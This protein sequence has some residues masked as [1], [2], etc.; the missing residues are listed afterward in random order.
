MTVTCSDLLGVTVVLYGELTLYALFLLTPP[1][2]FLGF[3]LWKLPSAVR[4]LRETPIGVRRF[5]SSSLAFLWLIC[6]ANIGRMAIQV[7]I[8]PSLSPVWKVTWCVR[9]SCDT[10]AVSAPS[11]TSRVVCLWRCSVVAQAGDAVHADVLPGG[12]GGLHLL[13]HP[14]RCIVRAGHL[15][16]PDG[17]IHEAP[18]RPDPH[19]LHGHL[20]HRLGHSGVQ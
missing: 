6:F 10:T 20:H 13:A 7:L 9:P 5:R 12:G 2:L 16:P 18:A 4:I 17:P 11:G 15:Q 3:L 1:A 14:P 8:P 19:C